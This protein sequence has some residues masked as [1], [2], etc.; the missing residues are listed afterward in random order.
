MQE[1]EAVVIGAGV[2]GLA[3]GRALAR[4]FRDV[5]IL[6][7]EPSH[8][9][10]T[11]SRNSEVIHAGLYYQAGSLK[12]ELCVLG[13]HQLYAYC[14]LHNIPHRK[15]QKLVFAYDAS[16]SK[17]LDAIMRSAQ[18]NGVDDLVRLSATEAARIEP[19]LHCHEALLSPSTGILDSHA[20]MLALLADAEADGATLACRTRV[21]RIEHR[22]GRYNLF[23][24]GE[25]GPVICTPNLINAAGLAAPAVAATIDAL[26]PSHIPRQYL[27]RGVYF[28]YSGRVPFSRLIYPIPPPGSLGTHLTLDLAGQARFGPDMEWIDQVDYTVDPARHAAFAEAA[29]RIWPALDPARLHPGYAGIRPK[30]SPEGAPA[31]DFRIDGPDQHGLDGLVNLFGIE[32]PGLTASLAIADHVIGKVSR[33]SG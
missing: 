14:A 13:K 18:A 27:L 12:A 29:S 8:G 2:V 6:E 4:S 28:T 15:T 23:I 31:V 3:I 9:T 32:S 19:A 26:D 33:I 1:I 5:F 20:Y 16:Q 11:S 21:T 17:D 10:W 30:L 22:H 24:E 25:P 7:G